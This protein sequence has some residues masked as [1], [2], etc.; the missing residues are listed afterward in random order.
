MTNMVY[1]DALT[2]LSYASPYPVILQLRKAMPVPFDDD[3]VT[4]D[5]SK[6]TSH[7]VYRSQSLDDLSKINRDRWTGPRKTWTQLRRVHHTK[8]DVEEIEGQLKKWSATQNMDS[9]DTAFLQAADVVDVN[10]SASNIS[11]DVSLDMEEIINTSTNNLL[12]ASTPGSAAVVQVEIPD[13][14]ASASAADKA[15]LVNGDSN[16]A[17]NDVTDGS[18][19]GEQTESEVS[20]G[21]R[22]DSAANSRPSSSES[23]GRR[24]SVS[25]LSSSSVD[26][27]GARVVTGSYDVTDVKEQTAIVASQDESAD[28]VKRDEKSVSFAADINENKIIVPSH[29]DGV[30]T[31][32]DS[33]VDESKEHV[34]DTAHNLDTDH[35][36]VTQPAEEPLD[37]TQ[38][39]LADLSMQVNVQESILVRDDP[40]TTAEDLSELQPTAPSE[41]QEDANVNSKIVETTAGPDVSAGADL[42]DI[43]G[44]LD[45]NDLS[46][47]ATIGDAYTTDADVTANTATVDLDSHDDE[48]RDILN[49]FF[50]DDPSLL[51]QFGFLGKSDSEQTSRDVT[52]TTITADDESYTTRTETIESSGTIQVN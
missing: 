8:E 33:V 38:L 1:E 30:E 27:Q 24:D 42:S 14:S 13:Q 41:P 12:L 9:D 19:A 36:N 18:A 23:E 22:K 47:D 32:A 11:T 26:E 25:S 49:D 44:L 37:D 4:D 17:A 10:A 39:T 52:I 2:I 45:A 15:A 7:P 3:D 51:E 20:N 34:I 6:L 5:L 28:A 40:D 50:S 21:V 31:K 16:D 35:A 46:V 43:L 29:G 48:V